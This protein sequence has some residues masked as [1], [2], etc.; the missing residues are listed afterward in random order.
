MTACSTIESA[1]EAMKLGAYHYVN[2]PFHLDEVALLVEKALETSHCAAKMHCW[3][4]QE[5]EFSFDAIIG[6][7]PAMRQVKHCWHGSPRPG[8]HRPAHRGNR[9]RQGSRGQRPSI[10]TA[11]APALIRQ[12]H[13]FGPARAAA[14]KRAVRPRTRG[15]HRRAAAEEGLFETA[16]GGTVFLDEIGEMTPRCR[17]SCCGFWRRRHSSVS[18]DW[19]TCESTSV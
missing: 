17:R 19:R 18:A 4:N 16:D 11:A 14:R 9:Y 13:L 10:T 6:E 15:V 1:V 12:H 2:K 3:S 8:V 7:S 5:R